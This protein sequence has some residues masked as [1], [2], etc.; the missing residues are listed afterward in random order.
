VLRERAWPVL[1]RVTISKEVPMV[2]T[3]LGIT[4]ASWAVV[5]ALSSVLQIR[6]IVR[7]RSSAGISVGYL[8]VLLVGFALW[9][10]YGI[11][12]DDLPLVV[13]NSVAFLVMGT[14]IAVARAHR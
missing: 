3:V 10:A 11:A 13:P 2:T 8:A 12:G 7:R 5:M 4:A 14:T 1:E 9:V 6:E